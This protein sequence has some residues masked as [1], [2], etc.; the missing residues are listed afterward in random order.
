[1]A[2]YVFRRVIQKKNSLRSAE[3]VKKK[4]TIAAFMK[5]GDIF[6]LS[7]FSWLILQSFLTG[8]LE[9]MAAKALLTTVDLTCVRH[10]HKQKARCYTHACMHVRRHEENTTMAGAG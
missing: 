7:A 10:T 2:S 4:K 1:M 8:N 5:K 9:L 6:P 3:G